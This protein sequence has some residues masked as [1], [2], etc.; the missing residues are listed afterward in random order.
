MNNLL[1]I[2]SEQYGEKIIETAGFTE[3]LGFGAMMV[4]IGTCTVFAVLIIIW[5]CL[6]GFK[7]I[8]HDMP[9]KRTS[10]IV[11]DTTVREEVAAPVVYSNNDEEIV[12]VIAAAIAMSESETSGIKF[13]VVSFKRK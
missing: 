6:S 4:L 11:P 12:A 2:T 7:L 13:R 1:S 5:A 3:T 10:K 9:A 8:F